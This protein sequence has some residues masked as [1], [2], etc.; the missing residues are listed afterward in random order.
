MLLAY[1]TR[2]RDGIDYTDLVLIPDKPDS[3]TV[4]TS[5]FLLSE[6][7]Y[8]VYRIG[9]EEAFITNLDTDGGLIIQPMEP[10][11]LYLTLN[12]PVR[13]GFR[14]RRIKL[15]RTG[16]RSCK[17]YYEKD[18]SGWEEYIANKQRV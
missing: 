16:E 7:I 14:V 10:A 3:L 17:V 9:P 1:L 6:T 2:V 4:P 18:R 8:A 11:G 12:L 15:I 5:V 13:P